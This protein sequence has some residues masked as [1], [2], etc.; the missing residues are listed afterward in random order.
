MQHNTIITTEKLATR[1]IKNEAASP[2]KT[3]N[4]N[5]FQNILKFSM[6]T[7]LH[8]RKTQNPGLGSQLLA[9]QFIRLATP[10]H[11]TVSLSATAKK[12]AVS[13]KCRLLGKRNFN[14]FEIT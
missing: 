4:Q 1:V 10:A 3:A 5:K 14:Y 13:K 12:L 2:H 9:C 8:E 7:H 11:Q 6:S